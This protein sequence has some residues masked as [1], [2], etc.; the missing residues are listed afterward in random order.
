M[1]ERGEPVTFGRL[2]VLGVPGGIVP[3]PA[4]L[5]VLLTAIALHR[6]ALGL[7]M[8]V[9]FSAGLAAVLIAIGIAVVKARGWIER[10]AGGGRLTRV[11]P[12]VSAVLITL[13]GI[14]IAFTGLRG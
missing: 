2:F 7:A 1:D 8:I 3:C 11:L 13:I 4:A 12:V 9:S 6:L 10:F 14:G 5:V